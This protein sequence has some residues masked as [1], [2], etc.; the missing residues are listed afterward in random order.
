M[1]RHA[2]A[3]GLGPRAR[4]GT[5]ACT[6]NCSRARNP[7]T[8]RTGPSARGPRRRHSWRPPPHKSDARPM[9]SER[10]GTKRDA[11]ARS[12]LKAS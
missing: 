7:G 5:A 12:S 9:P 3:Q 8:P 10:R 2:A 1:S 4:V 6:R 11:P